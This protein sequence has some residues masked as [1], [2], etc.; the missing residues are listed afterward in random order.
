MAFAGGSTNAATSMLQTEYEL[1]IPSS[2]FKDAFL[3]LM[4]HVFEPLL[5]ERDL[6]NEASVIDNERAGGVN[7]W[8]GR[9]KLEQHRL[10]RWKYQDLVTVHQHIG[11]HDDLYAMTVAD[12][13]AL[14]AAYFDPRAYVVIGGD[15]DLGLVTRELSKLEVKEHRL[16]AR[17]RKSGWTR[18]L[19]HHA[20]FTDV[21]SYTYHMAG[22]PETRRLEDVLAIRHIGRLLTNTTHGALYEWLRRDLGWC[23]SLDFSE[24]HGSE[25]YPADWEL[26]IPLD[27]FKKV[28]TMRRELR[29]RMEGALMDRE[30][31]EREHERIVSSRVFELQT[32]GSAV[33]TVDAI[34]SAYGKLVTD[35]DYADSFER[36]RDPRYLQR[37]YDRFMSPRVSGEFLAIP[38][39]PRK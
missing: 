16:P 38:E 20:R 36:C 25:I 9:N 3:G 19:F 8:P 30:L 39:K 4:S 21:E 28:Q 13:R 37:I 22:M 29:G 17:Y 2:H 32:L 7:W 10:I 35:K 24:S 33:D 18:R 14:H 12:L 23:Y 6:E 5:D 27:S 26:T 15:F 34:L 11:L 1:S 31:L